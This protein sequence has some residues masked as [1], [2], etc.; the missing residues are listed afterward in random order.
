MSLLG[1]AA[2]R[3]GRSDR[4][5]VVAQQGF[6]LIELMVSIAI[7]AILIGIA[8][9][10]YRSIIADQRVRASIS[11]LHSAISLARSE[12]VK[13]NRQ[14]TLSP[15]SGGWAAGWSIANPVSG[16]PAI[17]VHTLSSGV[18]ITGPSGGI[19]FSA[20]GRVS[21]AAEFEVSSDSSESA[22]L[23]CLELGLDGRASSEKGA[24]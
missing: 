8:V 1:N 18:G 13:L 22:S 24:C 2:S 16:Q 21:A 19:V 3:S 17:L 10:S 23:G 5:V 20:S 9:P 14:V 7:L 15:A 4:C 12:A 6:S 11:D